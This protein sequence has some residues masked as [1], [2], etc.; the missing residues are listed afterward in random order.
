MEKSKNTGL[1]VTIIILVIALLGTSVFIVY[2]KFINTTP[3][4][5]EVKKEE[6]NDNKEK[7]SIKFSYEDLEELYD[8]TLKLYDYDTYFTDCIWKNQNG[9]CFDISTASNDYMEISNYDEVVDSVLSKNGVEE[10]ENIMSD[11]ELLKN[12]GMGDGNIFKKE[13]GKIYM[14]Y[15]QQRLGDYYAQQNLKILS[16]SNN[17]VLASIQY[18]YIDD[19]NWSE[20]KFKVVYQDN[21]WLIDNFPWIEFYFD[22]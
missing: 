12:N 1:I 5:E 18:K 22:N 19:E 15:M 9:E 6:N 21:K 7:G 11:K 8:K 13:N 4:E 17:E 20:Y 10:Y 3:N 2:D 16:I 14:K